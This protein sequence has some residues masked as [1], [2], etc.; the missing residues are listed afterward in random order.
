MEGA[1]RRDILKLAAIGV[2][3]PWPLAAGGVSRA[4]QTVAGAGLADLARVFAVPPPD[5]RPGIFWYW[6]NGN[7]SRAGITADLE[8]MREAGIR[9]VMLFS[10]G[11]PGPETIVT[12]AAQSLTPEWWALV[13]FA[14]AEAGRLGLEIAMNACDGWATASGPWITPELSMQRLTWSETDVAGG[15]PTTILPPQPPTTADHYR[16]L[17]LVAYRHPRSWEDSAPSPRVSGSLAGHGADRLADPANTQVVID[18]DTAGDIVLRYERPFTLRSV[19]VRTPPF[20]GPFPGVQRAANR[21]IVE[22]SDDGATWRAVARLDYPRHGWETGLT[23]VLHALPPTRARL[24]RFRHVP[25]DAV[26][27]GEDLYHAGGPRLRLIG[28]YPSGRARVPML[29]LRT[30]EAWGRA[31]PL[32]DRVL[33]RAGCVAADAIIDLTGRLGADGVL[34]WRPPP[35]RWTIVRI[36]HTS[37]GKANSIAGGGKG[38]ECDKLSRAAARVQFAGWFGR[39]LNKVGPDLAG[40]VLH[41]FHVD[42]WEAGSQNWTPAFAAEFLAR[43]GYDLMPH[44]PI[45]AGVP[46]GSADAIERILFDVRR[47]IAELVSDAF[48]G[49]MAAQ[50]K[51]RGCLFSGETVNPTMIADGL[52]YGRHVDVP[53]GEFW[54][55]SPQNLKPHDIADAVS[56]AHIHGRRIVGAE[57]FT[58][59]DLKWDETPWMLKARGDH[60][61]AQGINRFYLHVYAHQP[62][63]DRAPGVTLSGVGTFLGRT[64]T[65]W[66]PGKAWID[67]L[68]RSQ[69]LLQVGQPVADVAMFIGEDIPAR[70]I[71]ADALPVAL[72]PGY[73]HDSINR[74]ALLRTARVED[75]ALIL[76][77]A[78]RYRVLILPDSDRMTPEL[79]ERLAVLAQAGLTIVGDV[80][81]RSLGGADGAATDARLR[82]AAAAMRLLPYADLPALLAR[83]CPPDALF[84]GDATT[85]EWTHRAAPAGDLYYVSNQGDRAVEVTAD[86]RAQGRPHVWRPDDATT[87]PMTAWRNAHGRTQCTL[88]LAPR[89]ALF[90]IVEPSAA[91]DPVIAVQGSGH[92]RLVARGGR[93]VLSSEGAGAWTVRRRSGRAIRLAIPPPPPAPAVGDWRVTFP[94]LGERAWPGL[95]RWDLSAEEGIR[96]FSGTAVYTARFRMARAGVGGLRWHL[97]LGTVADLADV[98]VNGRRVGTLWKPPF[99]IDV[100]DAIRAGDNRLTIAVTNTWLNRLIGDAPKADRTSFVTPE[101][102]FGKPWQPGAA[103]PLL[104]AGLIGPV[105]LR[106]SSEIAI[107]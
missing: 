33:P 84:G 31:S 91:G 92:A 14:I 51:A 5:A 81:T 68:A 105:R 77:G 52:D 79:A 1:A 30:G 69:A 106:P 86:L 83:T 9:T 58:E 3:L 41:V 21:L 48:F 8:A 99:V 74:D 15:R 78:M 20:P 62:F 34:D 60:H 38:L 101:L 94:G 36:G 40:R 46:V 64:Q 19:T 104:R 32:T 88:S 25:E 96:H 23:S 54:L 71:L 73:R 67:Y 10:V 16:D 2:A 39:A 100:T 72:P 4:G 27:H 28:L 75:G 63:L 45:L 13:R 65:W 56:T 103:D 43:R 59:W 98:T 35:G 49:E 107:P 61:F 89:D 44:L 93:G 55:R 26:A 7:V 97:D 18:S 87:Q 22:A 90:V 57:A 42:S 17:R 6:M 85:V 76:P 24:F 37:T 95:A 50:A 82:H 47:T 29:P 80:P 11:G 70:S 53:M 12:P 66:K 102:H